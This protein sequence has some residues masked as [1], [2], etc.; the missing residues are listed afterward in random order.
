MVAAYGCV[1]QVVCMSPVPLALGLAL[2]EEEYRGLQAEGMVR[3]LGVVEDQPV[4]ELRVEES[5]VGKEQVFVVVHEGLLQCAVEAFATGVHSGALGIGEPAPDA[6]VL[7]RFGE[8]SLELGA[9]ARE[10]HTGALTRTTC[11][12]RFMWAKVRRC[13]QGWTSTLRIRISGRT[14]WYLQ[15]WTRISTMPTSSILKHDW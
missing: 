14:Q 8:A 12:H 7:D 5:E 15:A 3:T 1:C 9:V 6:V 11:F 10:Q 13:F 4:G 2:D